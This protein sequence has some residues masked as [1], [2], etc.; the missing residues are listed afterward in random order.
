MFDFANQCL[1][2]EQSESNYFAHIE[3]CL[4]GST[5]CA[6]V[7]P[8]SCRLLLLSLWSSPSLVQTVL[9]SL[10]A[11]LCSRKQSFALQVVHPDCVGSLNHLWVLTSPS[12]IR[13]ILRSFGQSFAP[14]GNLLLFQ[15]VQ[16]AVEIDFNA[17]WLVLHCFKQS[18]APSRMSRLRKSI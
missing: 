6:T 11:A 8:P 15:E 13:A 2:F 3:P 10:E 17:Y 1:Q 12:L 16:A 14:S 4:L 7:L 18:S 5:L 9:R